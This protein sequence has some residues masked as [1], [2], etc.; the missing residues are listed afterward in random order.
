MVALSPALAAFK[1]ALDDFCQ[2]RVFF[3]ADELSAQAEVRAA[4]SALER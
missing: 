3:E 4:L 2:P 1:P